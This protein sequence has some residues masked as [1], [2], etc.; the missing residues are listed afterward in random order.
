VSRV[1]AA[2]RDTFRSLRVRNFRLFFIGQ[3][4]SQSGTWLTMIAQTLLVLHLTD[5]GL[6]V[7][8]LTACQFGPVLLLGAWA[9]V[10]A[11]RHEKR[12]LLLGVQS[13]AM[14][15][16][17][18]LAALA[19]MDQPPLLAIYA[20]ATVGGVAVALDNPARRSFV[21]EMVEQEDV[22]NAV[23]LNS[24]LMTSSRI[25]GPAMAA[26]LI[27]T[28]GYA[29]CFLIDG[30]SYVAVLVA[31]WL[32]DPARNRPAPVTARGRGQIRAGLRYAHSVPALWISLV[33]MGIVGTL[34]FN[35]Q[36]VF[37]LFVSRSLGGDDGAFALLFALTGV[38][39]LAGALHTARRRVARLRDVVTANAA[40][41]VAMLAMAVT[42]TLALANVMATV[43]GLTSIVFMTSSTA[44][45]QLRAEPTMRGRVLAL[46]SIVFLGSTPIGGPIL[47]VVSESLGPRVGIAIGGVG[48][49]AA[50]AWGA[51]AGRR[52]LAVAE[53]AA[54]GDALEASG[55][56]LRVA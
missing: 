18:A 46:Q 8:L 26:V 5:S 32:I 50:A 47:G 15:K 56:D 38:G 35:F 34:A 10:L 14:A 37:P 54:E 11:D 53:V 39:S 28:L 19:L 7:G 42:P 4:I 40:F 3:T 1:G 16:S 12:R 24:A 2:A 48:A 49:L 29:W 9:G 20:V 55:A 52:M 27:H 45:V 51:A 23:S 17:F 41:G 33:M 6:A 43:V 30:A 13:I 44:L 21:V 31:L 25:I 36:V 22:Q